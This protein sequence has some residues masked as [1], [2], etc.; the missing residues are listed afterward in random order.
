MSILF[1]LEAPRHAAAIDCL[2]RRAFDAGW[3]DRPASRL[4]AG[5]APVPDLCRVALDG[6]DGLIGTIRHY[7][8]RLGALPGLM[9]GPV[10]VEPA[11]RGRGVARALVRISLAQARADGWRRVVLVGD[12]A[13]YGRL[14]FEPAAPHGLRLPGSDDRLM[15]QA[16]APGGLD[17]IAGTVGADRRWV[18]RVAA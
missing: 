7:P 17:G 3:P 4:R 11:L 8:V 2:L 14:G 5:L 13:Y 10:A 12:P 6:D 16:L 18:R 15:V 1:E 9:L